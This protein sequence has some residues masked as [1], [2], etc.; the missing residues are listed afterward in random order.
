MTD[1]KAFPQ[2]KKKLAVWSLSLQSVLTTIEEKYS[3][4][5]WSYIFYNW[6]ALT[7]PHLPQRGSAAEQT[8]VVGVMLPTHIQPA[9]GFKSVAVKH[10][11]L[12]PSLRP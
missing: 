10:Q 4:V 6:L 3:S 11:L 9:I 2:K 5:T 7:L 1:C 8:V 12:E